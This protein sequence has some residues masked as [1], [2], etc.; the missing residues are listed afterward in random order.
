VPEWTAKILRHPSEPAQG[1][2][3]GSIDLL[4]TNR[5]PNFSLISA[6]SPQQFIGTLSYHI[7]CI[8]FPV[9]TSGNVVG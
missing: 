6:Q 3:L 2:K 5:G 7:S 4:G 1:D 9:N 8:F